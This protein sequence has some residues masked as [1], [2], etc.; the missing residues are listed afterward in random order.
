MLLGSPV[1]SR[2][3]AHESK[4]SLVPVL[5]WFSLLVFSFLW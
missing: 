1:R 5:V 4:L 3:G 2:C